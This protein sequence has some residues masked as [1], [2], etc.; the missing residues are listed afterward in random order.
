MLLA[1]AVRKHPELAD[2]TCVLM[3][4][5]QG[6]GDP[7]NDIAV[8]PLRP[9]IVVTASRV[10]RTP[11]NWVSCNEGPSVITS[12]WRSP[13]RLC[14]NTS[15]GPGAAGVEHTD[16]GVRRHPACRGRPQ[17]RDPQRGAPCVLPGRLPAPVAFSLSMVHAAWC[18]LLICS[19][20]ASGQDFHPTDVNRLVS[21]GMDNAVKVWSLTGKSHLF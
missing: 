17:E 5:A 11:S 9:S 15:A 8:H 7:I 21:A 14:A 19:C 13:S 6:H 12:T 10:G 18:R 20:L 2:A 1:D 4:T 16:E 3:Q